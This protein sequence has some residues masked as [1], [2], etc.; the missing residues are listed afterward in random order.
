MGSWKAAYNFHAR[1]P[2]R[3]ARFPIK[4]LRIAYHLVPNCKHWAVVQNAEARL[5]ALF[6]SKCRQ[7]ESE[8]RRIHCYQQER[9]ACTHSLCTAV[10]SCNAFPKTYVHESDE[11]L[12]TALCAAHDDTRAGMPQTLPAVISDANYADAAAVGGSRF[13][14]NL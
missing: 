6:P 4:R 14:G 10:R 8:R 11:T 1:G 12:P 3:A 13:R 5:A 9:A 2:Q 7:P